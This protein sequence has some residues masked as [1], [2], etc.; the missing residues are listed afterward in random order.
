MTGTRLRRGV[1]IGA[2]IG[3][4]FGL[5][6][7]VAPS[8]AGAAPGD[9]DP[10]FSGDGVQQ[11]NGTGDQP[12]LTDVAIAPDGGVVVVGHNQSGPTDDHLVLGRLLADGSPDPAFGGGDGLVELTPSQ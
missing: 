1:A 2:L 3:L 10:T 6:G 5:L 9:L 12:L 7:L 4:V 8:I 11:V